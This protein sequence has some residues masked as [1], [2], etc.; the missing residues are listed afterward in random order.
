MRVSGYESALDGVL[1][2][3]TL[4]LVLLL[5][6]VLLAAPVAPG[7]QRA[8]LRVSPD[9]ADCVPCE[10]PPGACWPNCCDSYTQY[11]VTNVRVTG[12]NT[13]GGTTATVSWTDTPSSASDHFDWWTQGSSTNHSFYPSGHSISLTGLTPYAVTNFW[14]VDYGTSCY[15][16]GLYQST[17]TS[18]KPHTLSLTIHVFNQSGTVSLTGHARTDGTT[19]TVYSPDTVPIAATITKSL[20]T[21]FGYWFTTVGSLAS[22]LSNSTSITIFTA[23]SSGDLTLFTELNGIGG[24]PPGPIGSGWAGIAESTSVAQPSISQVSGEFRLPT[25]VAW[26]PGSSTDGKYDGCVQMNMGSEV[27]MIWLGIGGVNNS[28]GDLWQAG[29]YLGL[30]QTGGPSIMMF[31]EDAFSATSYCP[32]Y[33]GFG[34]LINGQVGLY[35][36]V[37]AST[38]EPRLGDDIVIYLQVGKGTS[39]GN[40]G[41]PVGNV[42]IHDVT[43]NATW[44]KATPTEEY[45]LLQADKTTAEWIVEDSWTNTWTQLMAISPVNF[46]NMTVNKSPGSTAWIPVGGPYQQW[47][48][49]VWSNYGG[50]WKTYLYTPSVWTAVVPPTFSV[51][52][53]HTSGKYIPP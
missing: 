18:Y 26:T 38:W 1:R 2:L 15:Y 48:L 44:P 11:Y 24:A 28:G 53:S 34:G 8:P 31:V 17:L 43:Q 7:S 6:T 39:I 12:L 16:A 42:T 32:V 41:Q 5:A 51:V 49:P 47:V 13:S 23:A 37:P 40:L 21:S 36:G 4:P 19:V 45:P 35:S 9:G 3:P 33:S 10:S 25:S 27:T 50:T 46:T 22:R 29:I 20:Q 52:F 30:N 14:I